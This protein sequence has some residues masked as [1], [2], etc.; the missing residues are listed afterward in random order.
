MCED[1]SSSECLSDN[2][3]GLALMF[4]HAFGVE[5][6][7]ELDV[8]LE[9]LCESFCSEVGLGELERTPSKQSRE[10]LVVLEN[11]VE[12]ALVNSRSMNLEGTSNQQ[13]GEDPVVLENPVELASLDRILHGDTS[14]AEFYHVFH[15]CEESSDFESCSGELDVEGGLVELAVDMDMCAAVAR[16]KRNNT[17]IAGAASDAMWWLVDSGAS[18]HLINEE[19]LQ[20]VRVVSQT[21]HVLTV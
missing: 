15:E 2:E 5:T 16:S 21:E 3:P 19:T 10:D 18:T 11:P 7:D 6:E 17:D 14:E 20:G 8:E 12:L 13:S 1:D 9:S 4:E